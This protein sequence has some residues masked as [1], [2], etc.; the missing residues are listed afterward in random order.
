MKNMLIEL[1]FLKKQD[2]E[3]DKI[4]SSLKKRRWCKF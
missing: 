3:F 2:R 1:D 4:I